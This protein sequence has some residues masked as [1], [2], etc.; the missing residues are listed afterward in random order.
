MKLSKCF[1]LACYN[2]FCKIKYSLRMIRGSLF[3][4]TIILTTVLV[5]QGIHNYYNSITQ[6]EAYSNAVIINV[7]LDSYGKM[8]NT[9]KEL[10]QKVLEI[11]QIGVPSY[12]TKIDVPYSSGNE[13]NAYINIKRVT[14]IA[15]QDTYQ[16]IDDKSYNFT[17]SNNTT[18]KFEVKLYL[19]E[20]KTINNND[21]QEF[22]YHF[23]KSKLI[24][25]GSEMQNPKEIMISDYML[26]RF[27]ITDYNPLIGKKITLAID[28]KP[29][30][31]DFL[32]AG[33]I[34]EKLYRIGTYSLTPHILICGDSSDFVKFKCK[35]LIAYAPVNDFSNSLSVL[36]SLRQ[37]NIEKLVSYDADLAEQIFY[38]SQLSP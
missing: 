33:V 10:L 2:V 31:E 25:A 38:I 28:G 16:G 8:Y 27:G 22:S 6:G 11:P 9:Q 18:V 1:C 37:K 32:L 21:W 20:G 26:S 23:P 12:S 4:F 24:V 7:P 17:K 19:N 34:N 13:E 36:Q 5:V 35:S 3:I 29:Y 15:G 14:L 30:I